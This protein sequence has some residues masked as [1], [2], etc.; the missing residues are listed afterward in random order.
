MAG[1]AECVML[2]K[3]PFISEAVKILADILERMAF[4]MD[5]K[6]ASFRALSVAR[7]FIH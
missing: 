7:R 4:H 5:K 6:H 1:R 3:G 2:N